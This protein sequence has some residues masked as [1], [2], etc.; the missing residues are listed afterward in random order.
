[1]ASKVKMNTVK[2][3][4]FV[5]AILAYPLLLFV[6]FYLVLNFNSF[7]MAFQERDFLGNVTGWVGFENFKEFLRNLKSSPLLSVSLKN[8][9]ILY[10]AGLLIG[11]PLQLI[12]S[13]Y[14]FKKIPGHGIVRF[15]IMLPT[16]ISEFIVCLV[17]KKFVEGALPSMFASMGVLDFPN[18]IADAQYTFKTVVFYAVWMSFTTS[19][20]MYS[21]AMNQLPDEVFE[22]GKVDGI[23]EGMQ[24]LVYLALPMIFPTITTFLVTSF[25]GILTATGPLVSFFMLYAPQDSFTLGYYYYVE[26][27][28]SSSQ[29]NY[30]Y[31]AAGGLMLT[32]ISAPLTFLLKWALEKFGPNAEY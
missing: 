13:Y 23:T 3:Y 26:V 12:F 17:F 22:S 29:V 21:N 27:A 6:V 4:G 9:F 31:L 2:K 7:I 8:S 18:L 32:F 11:T 10:G 1:M 28:G 25:A 16:I 20:I 14:L 30:P 19:L 15:I 5:Y 24:E